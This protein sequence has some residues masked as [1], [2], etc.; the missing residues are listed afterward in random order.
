M[1]FPIGGRQDTEI[2]HTPIEGVETLLT[3][4]L[5]HLVAII[6]GL[7]RRKSGL[8]P[9]AEDEKEKALGNGMCGLIVSPRLNLQPH[10]G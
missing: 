4:A 3:G 7:F 1:R 9:F 10:I 2:S 6:D 5:E 8:A